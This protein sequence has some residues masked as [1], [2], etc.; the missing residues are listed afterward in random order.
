ML[1]VCSLALVSVTLALLGTVGATL[2][3]LAA[4]GLAGMV[5]LVAYPFSGAIVLTILYP[6]VE[7]EWRG[8]PLTKIYALLLLG[9]LTL[10]FIVQEARS[11]VPTQLRFPLLLPFL[12]LIAACLLSAL[13][14]TEPV[15]TVVR[16]LLQPGMMYVAVVVAYN[17]I[18]TGRQGMVVLGV[19]LAM[20]A[21]SA[22]LGWL[23]YFQGNFQQVSSF[24]PRVTPPAYLGGTHVSLA[25]LLTAMAPI[26]LSLAI[27][28]RRP[29]LRLLLIALNGLFAVTVVFTLSRAGWV[30]LALQLAVW[31]WLFRRHVW[32]VILALVG[33][34]GAALVALPLM[35]E[36]LGSNVRASSD[37]AR[38]YLS[39]LGLRLFLE[40]PLLGVGF[41]MFTSY[42]H[43]VFDSSFWPPRALDAHGMLYKVLSETGI[44]GLLAVGALLVGIGWRLFDAVQ[45]VSYNQRWRLV[46][47]GCLISF[48]V[49]T[50]FE[51]T[52]TRFY[53]LQ[54][55]FPI[56][57]Y[58]ALSRVALSEF[59]TAREQMPE[60]GAETVQP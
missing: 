57:V 47:L 32:L 1:L 43:V 46:L 49:S 12:A 44:V 48:A 54:Y 58:L 52:S 8:L 27:L 55:W 35:L 9:L 29:W 51:L 2:V 15:L 41:G 7:F 56:G 33:A 14:S 53:S 23:N 20:G 5:A 10:R 50:I 60:E 19:M 11:T 36:L 26:A 37:V 30:C 24:F 34:A 39:E 21:I 4:V 3:L 25:S 18:T 59:A 28:V 13:S 6:M 17:M 42:N 22:L 16:V 40:Q 45:K 31:V 38:D